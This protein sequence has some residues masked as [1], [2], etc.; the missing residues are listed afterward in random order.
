MAM[1]AILLTHARGGACARRLRECSRGISE[2]AYSLF[3]VI[4]AAHLA[5]LFVIPTPGF[6]L[7]Y[8]ALLA[9]LTSI[10]L[11]SADVAT[12]AD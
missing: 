12:R 7:Y 8:A 9:G 5:N 3:A 4:F 1:E 11:V 10:F 6:Q 2:A